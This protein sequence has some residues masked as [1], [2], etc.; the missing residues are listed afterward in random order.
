MKDASE[1]Y[2][3]KISYLEQAYQ[4][5]GKTDRNLYQFY[6]NI[7][8]D[9]QFYF[10]GR[11]ADLERILI[12]YAEYLENFF[13]DDP[14]ADYWRQIMYERFQLED[15]EVF[16]EE[17]V[18]IFI[19]VRTQNVLKWREV[20]DIENL[21]RERWD[22]L[23]RRIGEYHHRGIKE[24]AFQGGCVSV[25]NFLKE[26]GKFL[27]L[28]N[29]HIRDGGVDNFRWF[30][31]PKSRKILFY[32]PE[33]EPARRNSRKSSS[34]LSPRIA[35]TPKPLI[36]TKNVNNPV[37]SPASWKTGLGLGSRKVSVSVGPGPGVELGSDLPLRRGFSQ[38]SPKAQR[39]PWGK[40]VSFQDLMQTVASQQT[41]GG[42]IEMPDI[43]D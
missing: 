9:Q 43:A 17:V 27:V 8:Q 29:S 7:H 22:E 25:E 2:M 5:V 16:F 15:E 40:R 3:E 32:S 19:N 18:R 10:D 23:Q 42:D 13:T 26:L 11:R 36:S 20:V 1:R 14:A 35:R 38:S 31:D 34:A 4:A 33:R 37:T 6:L 39:G 24:K 41:P 21:F 30:Q 28:I 12:E